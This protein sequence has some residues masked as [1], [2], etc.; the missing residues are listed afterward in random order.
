MSHLPKM[1]TILA[2]GLVLVSLAACQDMPTEAGPVL[3]PDAPT[4]MQ[5]Q[6]Q[7]TVIVSNTGN[8][9]RN[10]EVPFTNGQ[11]F[12]GHITNLHLELDGDEVVASGR[13]VGRLDDQV[14]NQQFLDV[15]LGILQDLLGT[16]DD[17]FAVC[18]ILRVEAEN[19]FIDLLGLEVDL[20]L[21]L[22][23]RANPEGGLLGAVLEGLLC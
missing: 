9:I 23:I 1:G 5:S 20:D 4:L 14:I 11:T 17:A 6:A 2:S 15:A 16:G 18:R 22:E 7:Q 21:V 3:T 8:S 12:K 10:L 13:L 19:I